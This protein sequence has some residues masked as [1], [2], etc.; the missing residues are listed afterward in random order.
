MKLGAVVYPINPRLPT[1]ERDAEVE[2][3]DPSS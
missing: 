2:R 3:A 1:A